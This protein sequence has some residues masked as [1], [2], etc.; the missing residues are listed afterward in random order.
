MIHDLQIMLF[1]GKGGIAASECGNVISSLLRRSS[2]SEYLVRIS[3]RERKSKTSSKHQ[4]FPYNHRAALE[5]P[6]ASDELNTWMWSARAKKRTHIK[7]LDF[8]VPDHIV[9]NASNVPRYSDVVVD[10][11]TFGPQGFALFRELFGMIF[12]GN[13]R[14]SDNAYG[15]VRLVSSMEPIRRYKRLRVEGTAITVAPCTRQGLMLRRG[16]EPR[17]LHPWSLAVSAPGQQW[18]V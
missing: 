12:Q 7:C 17:R 8:A 18:S 2:N 16:L 10:G 4:P 3:I 11:Y 13:G 14:R 1:G 15:R 5:V 9:P 6:S